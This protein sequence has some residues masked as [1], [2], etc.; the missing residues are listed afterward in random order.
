MGKPWWILPVR[1]IRIFIDFISDV[2]YKFL[3]ESEKDDPERRIP[4][5]TD[6]LLLDSATTLAKKIREQTVTSVDII[7]IYIKRLKDV[8]SI[9]NGLVDQR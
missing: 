7:D 9:V 6:V 1:L 3:Y 5:V 4:P 2:I 8:N